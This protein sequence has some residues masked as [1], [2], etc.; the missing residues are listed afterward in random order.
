MSI[1]GNNILRECNTT[2]ND[3]VIEEICNIVNESENDNKSHIDSTIYE[4]LIEVIEEGANINI[5]KS[6][7]ANKKSFKAHNK[8]LKKALKA[9]DFTTAKSELKKMREDVKDIE[10][11]IYKNDSNAGSAICGFFA[12]GIGD[13]LELS[14]TGLIY[15]TGVKMVAKETIKAMFGGGSTVKASL[16]GF[17]V[18]F[19]GTYTLI[20]AISKVI[21]NITEIVAAFKSGDKASETFNLYRTRIKNAVENL[22]ASMDMIEDNIK[23]REESKNK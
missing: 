2:L 21:I 3:S 6:F 16:G 13:M 23:K 19:G 8:E 22:K 11:T 20:N 14:V 15:S 17:M 9:D 1:F 7:L 4:N 10:N 5:T 12:A 18:G